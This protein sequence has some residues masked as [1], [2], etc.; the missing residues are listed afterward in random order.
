MLDIFNR[1]SL[2][3]TNITGHTSSKYSR[4]SYPVQGDFLATD[5]TLAAGA[6][7]ENGNL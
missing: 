3:I 2:F 5:S 1:G 7:L 4:K 6:L